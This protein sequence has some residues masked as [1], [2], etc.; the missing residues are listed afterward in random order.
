M[1]LFL[2]LLGGVVGHGSHLPVFE[3]GYN[4]FLTKFVIPNPFAVFLAINEIAYL[5]GF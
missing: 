3:L 1:I 2:A 5:L 4:A